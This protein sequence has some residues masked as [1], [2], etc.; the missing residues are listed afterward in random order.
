ML[1]GILAMMYLE[2]AVIG[3]SFTGFSIVALIV[4][5]R[6]RNFSTSYLERERQAHADYT[7][8]LEERLAG[9][10]DIR[11]SGAQPY[12]LR[13]L[14]E[15]LRPLYRTGFKAYVI[16]QAAWGGGDAILMSGYIGAFAF[17]IYFFQS[18]VFTI[19]TVFLV[20]AY[21]GLL[22]IPLNRLVDEIEVLQHVGASITR[23]NALLHRKSLI[24]SERDLV[25]EEQA[26][27]V[28]FDQVFFRY[29][30]GDLVLKDISY[31]L[32]PGRLLGVL[33]R[34]GSGKTTMTR[35]LFRL[36]DPTG[37]RILLND[38]NLRH[39]RQSEI[40]RRIGL[41]T[42]EVQLFQASVRDNLTLFRRSIPDSRLIDLIHDVGLTTW[43]ES[44]DLGLDTILS[45]GGSGLSA[46]EA[47]LLVLK[48]IF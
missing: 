45:A 27:A 43:Y 15:L 6:L 14:C 3:L 5:Y 48:Q 24:K 2:H 34:T 4:M 10:E 19:G 28:S 32:P 1:S 46:G 8:F 29:G 39:I 37:G 44:L 26:L 41:V 25:I 7:G 40:P 36:Y 11:T 13:R 23:V 33:G 35:L 9:L 22:F 38:T 18:G 12:I 20:S 42:Q 30:D 17:S 31:H 21:A 47:Q 16:G